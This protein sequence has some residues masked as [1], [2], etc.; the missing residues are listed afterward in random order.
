MVLHDAAKDVRS[1]T[2]ELTI[3]RAVLKTRRR[4]SSPRSD[5]ALSADGLRL[6][7][8]HGLAAG[9]SAAVADGD[10]VGHEDDAAGRGEGEDGDDVAS[11]L[12]AEF[13]AIDAVL[14]RSEAAIE[15]AKRP[16]PAKGDRDKDPLVYDLDWDEDARLEKWRVVLRAGRKPASGAAGDGRP[17]CLE[18]IVGAAAAPW[19]GRL[20]AASVVRQAGISTT[21]HIAA[22]SLGLKTSSVD[23][24]RHRDRETRL[25]AIAHGLIATAEI[26]LKEHDGL[27]LARQMMERKLTGGRT[28]SKLPELVELV[29]ARPLVSAG[30]VLKTLNVTRHQGLTMGRM[31]ILT[32]V[33]RRRDWSDDEKLSILQEAA[34]PGARIADVARRH[35]IKPQQI[36]TW[37]RKFAAAQAEPVVSF[38]PVALIATE[39]SD[40]A[41]R[42]APDW[43]RNRSRMLSARAPLA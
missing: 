29:M 3:A 41:V 31:E 9:L 11:P 20:S 2:H 8:R 22:I 19:L 15:E 16:G 14:A 27:A 28:S 13:A 36:Y 4:I 21:A 25:L 43:A 23:R 35:D 18:R 30:M 39:A 38:L 17:R 40:E 6:P 37:R 33:E 42:P 26:G 5:W 12:D 34:E 1:P 32:G 10:A 24:H 7:R